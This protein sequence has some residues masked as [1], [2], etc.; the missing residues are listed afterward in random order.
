MNLEL[1]ILAPNIGFA[2][3]DSVV[4]MWFKTEESDLCLI[5]RLLI[6]LL[7]YFL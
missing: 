5:L 7:E 4:S 6:I 2:M 1:V 3:M